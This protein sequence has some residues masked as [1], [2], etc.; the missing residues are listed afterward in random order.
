MHLSKSKSDRLIA[1]TPGEPA[2]IGLDVCLLANAGLSKHQKYVYVADPRAMSERASQLKLSSTFNVLQNL[3]DYQPDAINIIP[4]ALDY[5]VTPGQLDTRS[6]PYVI[7]CLDRA[8]KLC[9]SG[10]ADALVTGPIQKSVVNDSGIEFSGHTEWL[11]DQTETEHVV[12]M[13]VSENL[14]VA[15]VTT[16]LPLSQVSAAINHEAVARTIKATAHALRHQFRIKTPRIAICGLNPHAGEGGHL[17]TEE[18]SIIQP[19]MSACSIPDLQLIGPLP[20]DTAFTQRNLLQCDAVIA[21]YHDQGLPV[22]KHQSFGHA[23]NIT[24]GLPIIRTSVDHG[25]ALDL[26]GSGAADPGSLVAAID[27]AASLIG[28]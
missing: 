1:I 19:A 21:M 28:L 17:G 9:T 4:I 15:L 27:L 18:I 7:E 11:A 13:L 10:D 22:L 20:A 5:P 23:V 16:H 14:R 2:G 12:M 3:E 8:L 6:G 26:A 24:L 25:T